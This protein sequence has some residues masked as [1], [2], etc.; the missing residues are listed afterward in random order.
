MSTEGQDSNDV[1]TD[2]EYSQ[3]GRPTKLLIHP[4]DVPDLKFPKEATQI[5]D[6]E[7]EISSVET[8]QC[9]EVNIGLDETWLTEA[10]GPKQRDCDEKDEISSSQKG[11]IWCS[12]RRMGDGWGKDTDTPQT[13]AGT[14]TFF[15]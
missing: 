11:G 7:D 15:L 13:K 2:A 8:I 9:T 14:F 5:R 3:F 10:T 1:P 6:I 12:L 4:K